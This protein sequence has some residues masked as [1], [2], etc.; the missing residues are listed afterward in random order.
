[1]SRGTNGFHAAVLLDGRGIWLSVF[2][3]FGGWRLHDE[4]GDIPQAVVLPSCSTT[5]LPTYSS[6]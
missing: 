5:M 4:H 2:S 6:G 3:L 1:M